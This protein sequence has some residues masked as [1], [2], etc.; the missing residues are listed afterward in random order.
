MI[1]FDRLLFNVMFGITIPLLCFILFWWGTFIFTN[2]Q[3]TIILAAMSGLGLGI[4]I[5]IL[6]KLIS[7]PDIYRLPVPVLILV[8]LFYNVVMFAMFMGVPFFHLLLGVGAGYYWAKYIEQHKEITSHATEIRRISLFASVVIAIVCFFS[9]S[10]ALLNQSTASELRSMFRL[11]FS[12]TR[13]SLL[14]L[15]VTGGL[16]MIVGQYLLVKITMSKTLKGN[17]NKKTS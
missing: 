5:S 3:K 6:I 17:E 11:P 8:Y 10:I 9:A 4:I 2:D 16:L 14:I 15:I 7:K 12:L 13:T 1:R